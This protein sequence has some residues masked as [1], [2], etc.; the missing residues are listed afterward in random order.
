MADVSITAANVRASERAIKLRGTA[1]ATI[2]A[3]QI[4]YRDTDEKFKLAQSTTRITSNIIGIATSGGA[5]GQTIEVVTRDPE[6]TVGGTLSLSAAAA[7]GAYVLS[8][9]AA[10]GIAPHGDLAATNWLVFLGVAISTTK[11]N[12]QVNNAQVQLVA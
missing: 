5:D 2:T 11:M 7:G 1:G 4:V 10:G 8:A 9:A 6:L 3:G 12:F